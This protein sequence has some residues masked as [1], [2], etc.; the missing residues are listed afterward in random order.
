MYCGMPLPLPPVSPCPTLSSRVKC[1]HCSW[2]GS[3]HATRCARHYQ[4]NHG[5][6]AGGGGAS[7]SG[8]ALS[9]E[10]GTSSN[11][12]TT[13]A[14]SGRG[15]KQLHITLNTHRRLS[16]QQQRDAEYIMVLMQLRYGL[17][18]Q[19]M[20]S[21]ELQAVMDAADCQLRIPCRKTLQRRQKELSDH[22]KRRVERR[23]AALKTVTL[24][25]DM[26]EDDGRHV[27]STV[28]DLC[29]SH[30]WRCTSRS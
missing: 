23:L 29:A 27:S 4:K 28:W 3:K 9:Q 14:P 17:S 25:V 22:T 30:C 8:D 24:G 26:W 19:A 21:P 18:L 1:R 13:S 11:A 15:L 2:T 6:H 16:K 12:S 10:T 7:S 5:Y 20:S